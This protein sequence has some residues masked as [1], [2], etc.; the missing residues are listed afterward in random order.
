MRRDRRCFVLGAIAAA[1]AVPGVARADGLVAQLSVN[2]TELRVGDELELE[3]EVRREGSGSVPDPELPA[4]LADAFEVTQSFRG[5]TGFQI[6]LGGGGSS[7]TMHSSM[8][9]TAIA[10][11]PGTHALSFTVDDG[12]KKVVSNVVEIVVTGAEA[13]AATPARPTTGKPTQP[14]GDVFVW[15]ATDKTE[16]WV[17]E[18]IEYRLDVY[19]RS[20][21]STVALRTPPNFADFYTHDLP[22][23]EGTV[24]EV[25]GVVYRVRPG[26]RRAL[27]PQ[28]AGTLVVGA[29]EITIG[30]RRRDRGAAVSIVVKPLP[31]EGQ[32]KGFSP[33]NVGTFAVKAKLDRTAVK[34]GQPFTWTIE[35]AGEGNIALI[36]PGPW[37]ELRGARRYDPKVDTQVQAVDRVRGRRTYALLVIPER[38]GTL[39]LPAIELH[40]FDPSTARYEI[41]RSEPLQ[42][43]VEGSVEPP[44]PTPATSDAA[45]EP[46]LESFAPIVEAAGLPREA[47]P[48]RWMTPGRW[49]WAT[50]AIPALFVA[51]WGG[52][53]AWRRFGPDEAARRRATARRIQ[54]ERIDAATAAVDTG[55]GFHA[56]IAS[57]LLEQAVARAGA[58]ATGLPRPAL[59]RLLAER[60]VRPEDV[61]SLEALLERCDAARFAAQRGSA[62]ERRATLDD[63]L[64]LV[65]RSSL[66]RGPA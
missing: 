22:E 9:I 28:K 36:D 13:A 52:T 58:E 62:D 64:A 21:L 4:G 3:L 55:E 30:R 56:A 2:A 11:K 47:P 35:I 27:F 45:P 65:E 5:G 34:A 33:N 26:M 19:E 48:A 12:G 1:V 40:F 29:P 39:E 41:A 50:G 23:G 53:A 32:P 63:A 10:L 57:L 7:R 61:R 66:S 20:L 6:T 54:R 49:G 60:K 25:G 16:A 59:L 44:T 38:G 43:E 8:S 24:E 14:D 51:V 15:A 31:A 17:G 18:Q 46:G 42:V 37:P